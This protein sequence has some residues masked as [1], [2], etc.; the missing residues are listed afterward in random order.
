VGS[1]GGYPDPRSGS[2]SGVRRA[3]LPVARTKV[4]GAAF[5][6]LG[7]PGVAEPGTEDRKGL[8]V[9]LGAGFS[10]AVNAVMPLTDEL[11]ERVSERVTKADQAR[12]PPP[13]PDGKR[14][15]GG[16]FEEWLSYLAEEQPHLTED[17]GL[18]ARALL[19]RVVREMRDVLSEAQGEAMRP[20]HDWRTLSSC[21]SPSKV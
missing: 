6:A 18:E 16:R 11:G 21:G 9:V 19:V 2:G 8:V 10:Y 3:P 1:R 20:G 4:A 14:F 5:P 7:C 13:G 15:N 12:L 17:Q